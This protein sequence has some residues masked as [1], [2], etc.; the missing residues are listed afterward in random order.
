MH[1]LIDKRKMKSGDVFSLVE[2]YPPLSMY[3]MS[4]PLMKQ[5]L[6]AE[7]VKLYSFTCQHD[8]PSSVIDWDDDEFNEELCHVND[9][10]FGNLV[11]VIHDSVDCETDI[12]QMKVAVTYIKEVTKNRMIRNIVSLKSVIQTI[13]LQSFQNFLHSTYWYTRLNGKPYSSI[14]DR[15]FGW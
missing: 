10:H 14:I 3:V 4:L 7:W 9:L 1:T 5:R 15:C 12:Y 11:Q 8:P 2:T 6:L 13:E